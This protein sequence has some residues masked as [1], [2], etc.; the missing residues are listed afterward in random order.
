MIVG[1]P[2]GCIALFA[3]ICGFVVY[4]HKRKRALPPA[5]IPMARNQNV[6]AGIYPMP[7]AFQAP[8]TIS[9]PGAGANRMEAPPPS[10]DL[11]MTHF[12]P[13]E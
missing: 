8:Y 6:R 5:C 11:A 3:G 10:Y 12:K 9:M 13:Q 4:Q 1:I 7:N 2:I